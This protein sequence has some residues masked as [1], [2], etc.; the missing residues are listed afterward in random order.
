MKHTGVSGLQSWAPTKIPDN[1]QSVYL[2][3]FA[4]RHAK[5]Q[6]NH[7]KHKFSLANGTN[8]VYTP[9]VLTRGYYR[10]GY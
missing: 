10:T 8:I 1:L 2:F 6:K 5:K 7:I 4:A 9:A 3:I